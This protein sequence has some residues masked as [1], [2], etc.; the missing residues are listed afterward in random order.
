MTNGMKSSL[1][2]SACCIALLISGCAKRQSGTR[3]VYVASLPSTPSSAPEADSGTLVIEEPETPQPV[4]PQ[5]QVPAPTS[6]TDTQPEES[7][8]RRPSPPRTTAE[9]SPEAPL[10][11]PPLEP[12]KEA[13]QVDRQK[14]QTAQ[15]DVQVRLAQLEKTL[16]SDA[17]KQT[18]AQARAFWYQSK[19]ALDEGDLPRAK[20]LAD[21]AHLLITALEKGP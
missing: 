3:L 19:R 20:N 9:P 2:T 14:I 17:E 21:K 7:K 13:G 8:P 1:W 6:A 5:P 4:Q 18:L 11:A 15:N 12:A 16:H 10:V